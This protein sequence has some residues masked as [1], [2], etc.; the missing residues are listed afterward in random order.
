MAPAYKSAT[1]RI[2]MQVSAMVKERSG[3]ATARHTKQ[4]VNFLTVKKQSV[5]QS[6]C[7]GTQPSSTRW[8]AKSRVLCP[9]RHS[10]LTQL[11]EQPRLTTRA[12]RGR[13]CVCFVG[14]VSPFQ[15]LGTPHIHWVIAIHLFILVSSTIY[16]RNARNHDCIVGDLTA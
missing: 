1:R 7:Q 4:G 5:M 3:R 13:C 15:S 12:F 16:T 14:G 8:M 6:T 11:E 2:D 10:A 9:Q